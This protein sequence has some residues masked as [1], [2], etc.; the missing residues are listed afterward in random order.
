MVLPIPDFGLAPPWM[1]IH[2]VYFLP[3][4]VEHTLNTFSLMKIPVLGFRCVSECL[5]TRPI[6]SFF[7]YEPDK[8]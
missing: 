8:S 4:Y 3:R 6:I 7:P 5:K 1:F 2:L